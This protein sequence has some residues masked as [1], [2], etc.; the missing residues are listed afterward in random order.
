MIH[1]L[2]SVIDERCFNFVSFK[3]NKLRNQLNHHLQFVVAPYAQLFFTL[4]N[5]QYATTFEN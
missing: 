5:F 4:E 3:K 2:S 1:I